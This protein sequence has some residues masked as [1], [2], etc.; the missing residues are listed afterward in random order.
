MRL[1]A[2]RS[3]KKIFAAKA[4]RHMNWSQAASVRCQGFT[5]TWNLTPPTLCASEPRR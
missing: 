3:S 4:L 5:G 1:C 2:D